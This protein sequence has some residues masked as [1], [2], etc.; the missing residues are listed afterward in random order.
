MALK[1]RRPFTR[2]AVVLR[3]SSCVAPAGTATPATAATLALDISL[4]P[5]P[6]PMPSAAPCLTPASVVAAVGF[7]MPATRWIRKLAAEEPSPATL[8]PPTRTRATG[9]PPDRVPMV[10]PL[11][12]ATYQSAVSP[13]SAFYNTFARAWELGVGAL[14]LC[15]IGLYHVL[16]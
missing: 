13:H 15:T 1:I 5:V 10:L 2:K 14:P 16:F 11:A 8:S 7:L 6:G 3:F 12:W 9:L 4:P